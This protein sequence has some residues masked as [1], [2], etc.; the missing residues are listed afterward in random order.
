MVSLL[1]RLKVCIVIV[2]MGVVKFSN[3]GM[4]VV[5][6]GMLLICWCGLI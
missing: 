2:M 3:V 6:V 1:L 4:L 5:N